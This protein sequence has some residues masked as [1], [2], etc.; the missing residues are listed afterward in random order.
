MSARYWWRITLATL[1][2]LAWAA[3]P[4]AVAAPPPFGGLTQLPGDAGCVTD[5][6]NTGLCADGDHLQTDGYPVPAISPDGR[7]VYLPADDSDAFGVFARD[8]ATG[9]I[10]QLPAPAGCVAGNPAPVPGCSHGSG[11][12]NPLGAAVSGDGRSLYVASHG[13]D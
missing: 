3:T 13:G 9:A 12:T 7:N 8:P 1:A 6:G 11:V 10:A 2:V 5:S 4:S